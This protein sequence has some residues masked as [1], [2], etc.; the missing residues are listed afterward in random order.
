MPTHRQ[1]PAPSPSPHA[2]ASPSFSSHQLV[3]LS[4]I[5]VHLMM[6]NSLS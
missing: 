4:K 2:P 6:S 1:H 3:F 5:S